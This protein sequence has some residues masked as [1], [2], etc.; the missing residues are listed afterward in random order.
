MKRKNLSWI[1][2]IIVTII[3]SLTTI[4]VT[5]IQTNNKAR[6]MNVIKFHQR[7]YENKEKPFAKVKLSRKGFYVETNK[8]VQP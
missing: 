6:S 3:T 7:H 8:G 1:V 4:A 5:Y 2:P